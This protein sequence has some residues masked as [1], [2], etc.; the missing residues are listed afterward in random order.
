ML[1]PLQA[2]EH[3]RKGQHLQKN[4]LQE[5]DPFQHENGGLNRTKA[6][7]P[8]LLEM[9]HP[10]GQGVSPEA[11]PA[12]TA[13]F[14]SSLSQPTP[15]PSSQGCLRMLPAPQQLSLLMAVFG[16]TASLLLQLSR[17]QEEV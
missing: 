13:Q 17:E 11:A 12:G 6:K 1:H 16:R 3:S 7:G 5:T 9:L 10:P 4:S 14:P 8:M 15:C 2:A